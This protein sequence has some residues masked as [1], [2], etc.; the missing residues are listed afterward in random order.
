MKGRILFRHVVSIQLLAISLYLAG[1]E[2]GDGSGENA[3]DSGAGAGSDS[4]SSGR[5]DI[6]VPDYWSNCPTF[7]IYGQP[8][9]TDAGLNIVVDRMYGDGEDPLSRLW[10]FCFTRGVD[11]ERYRIDLRGLLTNL[12][13]P[14]DE[15]GETGNVEFFGIQMTVLPEE[16]P[17]VPPG[18]VP[19][20]QRQ[21]DWRV[22]ITGASLILLFYPCDKGTGQV[23][24]LKMEGSWDMVRFFRDEW[25]EVQ[26]YVVDYI[27]LRDEEGNIVEEWGYCGVHGSCDDAGTPEAGAPDAGIADTGGPDART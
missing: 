27:V 14:G 3:T 5:T 7:T 15:Q 20:T 12:V 1:C 4:S 16:N 23:P 2:E 24:H 11:C 19:G 17:P 18:V 21:L 10:V 13:L 8:M 9:Y 22:E 25:D 26:D 6:G